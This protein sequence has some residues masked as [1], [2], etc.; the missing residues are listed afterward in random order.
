MKKLAVLFLALVM[1]IGVLSA[2]GRDSDS[3][4]GKA[5]SGGDS[6]QS[7]KGNS[8]KNESGNS[9]KITAPKPDHLLIWADQ[10]KEAGLKP[11]VKS[12]EKK[13]GIDVKYKTMDIA[14]KLRKQ[15][16]L[17]GPAGTGPDVFTVPHDQIGQ[18]AVQGLVRPIDVPKS[19][20]DIYTKSS[21]QAETYKGKL[22]GLPKTVETPILMY[23]KK[24]IKQ[25]PKTFK[26]LWKL[27]E[28]LKAKGKYGFLFL[29]DNYYF[30]HAYMAAYGGYVFKNKN[31]TLD[32]TDL[33]INNA[34]AVKGAEWIAK[35]YKQGLF[36]DGIVG[37]NGGSAMNGLWTDGKV[38]SKNDGPW[39]YESSEKA[40]LK[41]GAAP[42]PKLPNGKYPE[43]FIG[44]KGWQVSAFTKHPQWAT[45][46]VVW[47]SN[48]KNSKIRYQNTG[49]I[50]PIKSL[51]ND[52][53]I[54][55]N[56]KS[57]AV[58]VQAQRG[59]PMPNIPEMSQ[60]WGPMASAL[61]EIVTGKSDAK[62]AL[63]EAAKTINT[64]IKQLNSK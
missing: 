9:S 42:L 15:L 57:K 33:G 20:T 18:L 28:K 53:I 24:Y 23:N 49:E 10:E 45:K 16:R 54:K 46:L 61:Q 29:G 36:P 32:P 7:A 2:C 44:V 31:G 60:V 25:P 5:S 55:D 17:D 6:S 56:P 47:L 43:T 48:K 1:V 40:G 22:Y 37:K 50:P 63:D 52:P 39:A 12:F 26:E 30:A 11:A 4:S 19:V 13:F 64:K 58:F 27:S 38:A 35:W 14:S 51:I 62:T 59:E 21:I 34:G 41:F 8:S 3:S